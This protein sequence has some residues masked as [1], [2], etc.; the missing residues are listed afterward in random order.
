MVKKQLNE[1][2]FPHNFPCKCYGDLLCDRS[3]FTVQSNLS[4][5]FNFLFGMHNIE[6]ITV[7]KI[8]V[9]TPIVY[10]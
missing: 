5:R 8:D 4:L 2:T 7:S 6:K 1:T 9:E 10:P 3:Q